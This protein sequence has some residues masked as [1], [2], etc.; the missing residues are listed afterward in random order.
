MFEPLMQLF[1]IKENV[2]QRSQTSK[3]IRSVSEI[4]KGYFYAMPR[5]LGGYNVFKVLAMDDNGVHVRSYSNVYPKAPTA[6]NVESL[7][8]KSFDTD[9]EAIDLGMGHL[10]VSYESFMTW[11]AIAIDQYEAV[12]EE[13]LEG[14]RLWQQANVG[15]F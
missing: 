10:P 5:E 9:V 11:G 1:Q 4:K 3:P 7:F 12:S 8:M 13:Q 14:Y 15:Y 6:L 2:E